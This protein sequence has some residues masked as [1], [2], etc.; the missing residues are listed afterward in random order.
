MKIITAR[1]Q[2]LP[3]LNRALCAV[4]R[5]STIPILDNLLI[6]VTD[7]ATARITGTDL[8]I[9]ITA[10]A[11]ID[12]ASESGQITLD[13]GKLHDIVKLLPTGAPLTIDQKGDRCVLTSGRSRYTIGSLPADQFPDFDSE[14]DKLT[15]T[16]P[17]GTLRTL[18][19]RVAYAMAVSDVRYYLNS[20]MLEAP[21]TTLLAVASDGHRLALAEEPIEDELPSGQ[22]IVP[23]KG[24]AELLKMLGD[25]KAIVTLGLGTTTLTAAIGGVE[26]SAKLIV[27][28]YAD[29]KRV[30]PKTTPHAMTIKRDELI[31]GLRRVILISKDEHFGVKLAIESFRVKISA[32]NSDGE[33]ADEEIPCLFDGGQAD[34]AFNAQY[35]IDALA[36]VETE[37]A[38]IRFGEGTGAA[39][40]EDGASERF[41]GIVMPM[42]I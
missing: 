36:P 2:L 29:W 12:S 42:R 3:A 5:R 37:D 6:E 15:A 19:R 10:E 1:E 14:H 28:K 20:L 27:G 26:F 7:E 13:A 23:R 24:A 9:Q 40:I 18:L 31:A 16:I 25:D 21:G 41:R 30:V 38:V 8:E 35:L 32:A 17:A 22:W 39:V 11:T 33:E 4:S 34:G